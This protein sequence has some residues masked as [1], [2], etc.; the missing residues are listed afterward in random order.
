LTI[1]GGSLPTFAT[2]AFQVPRLASQNNSQFGGGAPQTIFTIDPNLRAPYVQEWNLGIQHEVGWSTVVDIHYIGNKGTK[3]YRGIDYNQVDI[4]TNGFV[5]DFLRARS[6][7][8]IAL[9]TPASTPGC[10]STTC[11]VFRVA[12]NANLPGSQVLTILPSFGFLTNSTVVSQIQ[13]GQPGDL[14]F[15]Y[16]SSAITGSVPLVPNPVA[17]VADILTNGGDSTYHAGVVE[18]RRRFTKGLG[19]QANYAFGKVLSDVGATGGLGQTRFDPYIDFNQAHRDRARA[20]FDV[21]HQFKANFV[22]ELPAGRGHWFNM[23]NVVAE[24]FLSGWTI[25][26]VFNWQSGNPFSISSGRGTLNRSGRCNGRCSADSNLTASQ[27]QNLVGVF[28]DST[29][30]YMINPAVINPS[31]SDAGRGV[32]ADA[33]T[34]N[35]SS[36][37]GQAFCHP[38]PGTLGNLQHLAFTGPSLF[39]WDFSIIKETPITEAIKFEYRA[40]FFNFLN[41]PVFDTTDEVVSSNQF[42]RFTGVAV[43]SRRI[44]MTLRLTF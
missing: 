19:F 20:L 1:S 44:Q 13:T 2:P 41:H 27:I 23:D 11:G 14:A 29:G 15:T 17:G 40:E 12:F 42:G 7:G 9:N 4:F 24:K 5:D 38:A 10:T 22:Y 36:F 28:H 31:G 39:T 18:V 32:G 35:F 21:T 8:F 43:A 34:C 16:H 6:N 25:S 30:V 26:S 33:N 3:L 37:P